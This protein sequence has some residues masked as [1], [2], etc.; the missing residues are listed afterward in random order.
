MSRIDSPLLRAARQVP[1]RSC[2][3]AGALGAMLL[4]LGA[5]SSTGQKISQQPDW[6]D[7]QSARY[8]A[9]EYLLGRGSA[10][11]VELAQ[12]RARADLAKVFEVTVQVDSSD[13]QR[14]K[15][16]GTATTYE[17]ASQQRIVTRTER[18]ISGLRIAEL[19]SAPVPEAGGGGRQHALAVLPRM[20]AGLAL[21][22]EIASRDEA[23]GRQLDAARASQDALQRAGHAGRAVE[24]A[25]QRSGFEQSLRVVDLAGRGVDSPFSLARLQ[26]DLEQ[27]LPRVV[28]NPTV[29][30]SEALDASALLTVLKGAI[31]GAGFVAG[32]EITGNASG[33]T[34][35]AGGYT[36]RLRTRLDG[37]DI[38]GWFWLRG[39][40]ELTLSDASGRVR[41]SK[42]WPLKLSAQEESAANGRALLAIEQ[43][44][45]RELR[46]AVLGFAAP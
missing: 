3:L 28:L 24:L 30:T 40:L 44:L 19:W 14:A 6:V 8:P 18:V 26:A 27:Q 42:A 17:A 12:E 22:Q 35:D 20:P 13:S 7:G 33:D 31:A 46:V 25:R 1:R 34:S 11:T 29:V 36:L 43:L 21:R 4:L 9:G 32:S 41:G 39:N 37:Q 45:Q 23:I 5:C 2:R 10:D 16:V 38:D 15:N